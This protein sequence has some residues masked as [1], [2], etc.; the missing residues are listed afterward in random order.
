MTE[1]GFAFQTYHGLI[2]VILIHQGFQ[3]MPRTVFGEGLSKR[4][5]QRR[6]INGCTGCQ[7]RFKKVLSRKVYQGR[8]KKVLSRKVYQGRFIKEGLSRMVYQ[9]RLS[10]KFN[11]GRFIKEGLSR[12]VYQGKFKKGLLR[13]VLSNFF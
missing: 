3:R 9:G 11:Q 4:F 2:M 5:F 12:M 7:G 1:S 10:R 8:F 13:K 6:F